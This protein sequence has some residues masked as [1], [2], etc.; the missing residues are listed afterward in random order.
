MCRGHNRDGTITT[1]NDELGAFR[2][3]GMIRI[4]GAADGPLKG[5]TFGVKDLFDVAG[6]TT[7]AGN[8]DFLSGRSPAT[9]HAPPVQS[10]LDAGATLVGK[11]ITDEI[12]FGLVGE[13]YHYG[14]PRNSA[15]PERV[16][17]GS[18]SGSVSVVAGGVCD[19]ALGTDTGGSVRVPA[20]HCGVYGLRTSHGRIAVEGLVPLAHSFDTVGWFARDPETLMRVGEVLLPDFAVQQAP[21]RLLIVNDAL[22]ELV[23]SAVGPVGA[24]I[25]KLTAAFATVEH[26]NLTSG[27]LS[28]WR[29]VFRDV[30]G[31]EAWHNHGNWIETEDPK[32]GPGVDE[33]FAAVAKI[34]KEDS[35]AASATRA[36]IRKQVRGLLDARTVLCVPS[37][38]G[39]APLKNTPPAALED[40]RNRTLNI[41]CIAGLSGLPQ[42]SLPKAMVEDCPVGISLIGMAGGEEILLR[43]AVDI[44]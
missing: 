31:Y 10:L 14:T 6:M 39:P 12:A 28:E 40:F 37:A 36:R 44:G 1:M 17:G 29:G 27:G 30:Q 42:I 38:A 20:S 43:A 26:V 41:C 3:D 13:N 23:P 9:R 22:A 7:G 34:T 2:P 15:A 4:D 32:F 25:D 5:M 33:R 21:T 18:S 19:T 16:P 24:A 11:T 35:D 8:P